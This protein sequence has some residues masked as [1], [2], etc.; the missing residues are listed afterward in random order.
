ME[1]QASKHEDN[2]VTLGFDTNDN[3][4]HFLSTNAVSFRKPC[5]VSTGER[6]VVQNTR[7]KVCFGEDSRNFERSSDAVLG[8]GRKDVLLATDAAAGT[9][10]VWRNQC[11][12]QQSSIT[13]GFGSESLEERLNLTANRV[14]Q[15]TNSEVGIRQTSAR[16]STA[17]RE[18]PSK[19][20]SA[21]ETAA[22]HTKRCWVSGYDPAQW[23]STVIEAY[24]PKSTEHTVL[25]TDGDRLASWTTGFGSA[26]YRSVTKDSY[27]IG[28]E[29]A[30]I[31]QSS[32]VNRTSSRWV[33]DPTVYKLKTTNLA[34]KHYQ[35]V[36]ACELAKP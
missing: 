20:P 18:K 16:N 29:T 19:P 27:G 30:E 28:S 8:G 6:V 7:S 23:V 24:Q 1:K 12:L 5:N 17:Q 33:G 9:C 10:E 15:P 25:G 2:G 34:S 4:W 14:V 26:E 11:A 36:S 35:A 13:V 31:P 21:S 3:H 32:T 22:S